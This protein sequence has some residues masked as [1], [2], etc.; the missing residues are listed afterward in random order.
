MLSDHFL[1]KR[2]RTLYVPVRDTISVDVRVVKQHGQFTFLYSRTSIFKGSRCHVYLRW[3]LGK[4]PHGHLNI[5]LAKRC[6]YCNSSP[7]MLTRDHIMPKCK[8]YRR[9]PA[10][11]AMVCEQCNTSKGGRTLGEWMHLQ[12]S[13]GLSF[14]NRFYH[15]QVFMRSR[16][17][18]LDVYRDWLMY[19][20]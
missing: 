5:R 4:P 14:L 13:H 1:S 2:G 3:D 6:A 17:L 9:S 15:I 16:V 20:R 19:F 10:N 18:L 8:G 11:I 7:R 12:R